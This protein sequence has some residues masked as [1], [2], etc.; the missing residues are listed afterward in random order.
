MKPPNCHPHAEDLGR[1][2]AGSLAV[3]PESVSAY[4]LRSSAQC[5]AVDLCICFHQ[6]LDEGSAITI[7]L[8]ELQ[9]RHNTQ[10]FHGTSGDQTQIF[11]LCGQHFNN[12]AVAPGFGTNSVREMRKQIHVYGAGEVV[13]QFKVLA[14]LPEDPNRCQ[15]ILKAG[16]E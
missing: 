6:L 11:A 12:E 8:L 7:R 9:T 10:L 13:Q 14:A 4:Q 5:L 2:P 3:D 15:A 16:P 1:S